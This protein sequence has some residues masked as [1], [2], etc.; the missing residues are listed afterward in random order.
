V[1]RL[2]VLIDASDL[3][4]VWVYSIQIS[5]SVARVAMR[6]L[7]DEIFDIQVLKKKSHKLWRFNATGMCD[8]TTGLSN[9]LGGVA[10]AP[11][12]MMTKVRPSQILITAVPCRRAVLQCP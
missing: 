11:F 3:E 4:P 2:L 10:V 12:D 1:A 6:S 5:Q 9:V 7:L 8:A